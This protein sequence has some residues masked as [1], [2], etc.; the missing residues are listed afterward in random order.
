MVSDMQSIDNKKT[1]REL[2]K[3]TGILAIGHF[4]TKIVNFFL[5]PLYTAILVPAEYGL[6]DLLFTCVVF[7]A[8]FVGLQL[9]QGAFRFLA[10]VR[11]DKAETATV[12]SCVVFLTMAMCA[13]YGIVFL[14]VSPW[15]RLPHKWYI[16]LHVWTFVFLHLTGG[17]CRGYGKNAIYA[18]GNFLSAS[19]VIVLNVLFL[20]VFRLGVKGMLCAYVLGPLLGGSF[21]FF[22]GGI[23]RNLSLASI[24]KREMLGI[25][26]YSVPLVPNEVSWSVIHVSDRMI[27][28]SILSVAANG[29]IAVAAKLSVLY[30]T[31]FGVFNLSWTEQVVLHFKDEGG[32]EYVNR[33][34]E[35]MIS[36]FGS[37]AVSLI[38]ALPFLFPLLVNDS[39]SAAYYLIPIYFCAVFFNAVIGL[40]S[41]IYL[42]HNETKQVAASTMVAAAINVAVDLA[43]IKFVGVYAAP[44]S[45]FCAYAA[46]SFWR[47]YDVNKRHCRISMARSK[48]LLLLGM[49][50]LS[51][52]S[53]YGHGFLLHATNLAII[54][55]LGLWLNFSLIKNFKSLLVHK[56]NA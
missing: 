43:L 15:V 37:V 25:V 22:K 12:T 6:V 4:G 14:L 32:P 19:C 31:V 10:P 42:V 56:M 39:F 30:T 20:L 45:S 55:G 52:V 48:V 3:N 36:F 29:L 13:A 8:V 40:I 1:S 23:Y 51:L 54:L 28:S 9:Y 5:L 50:A 21:L 49:L 26:R 53:V 2:F 18:M 16:L 46:I 27:V 34:F 7:L 24:N 38:A 17:I 11:M 44:I 35:Q 41:A 33:M 47:L